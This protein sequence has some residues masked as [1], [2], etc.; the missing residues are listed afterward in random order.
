MIRTIVFDLDDTLFPER[1]F[2]RSGFR[3]AARHPALAQVG[4]ASEAWQLFESGH[5][6]D[7][8]NVALERLSIPATLDLIQELLQ[9][10]RAHLPDIALFEDARWAIERFSD[11]HRLGA[12]ID[13]YHKTQQKKVEA[14]GLEPYLTPIIYS[15]AF[16]RESWK[17][18]PRPYEEYIKASGFEADECCYVGDNATKDFLA[19]NRLGW[20][21]IH[22]VRPGGEY[23]NKPAPLDGEA[24]YRIGSLYELEEVVMQ[25]A[26]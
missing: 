1:D 7:V 15:D 23:E 12:I 2:V 13:G 4:F 16:G 3:A 10:Y 8:F 18:S 6:N 5:R 26:S 21:T 9:L 19:A 17:P 25:F 14:L 20:T 11:S 22:I 24:Q